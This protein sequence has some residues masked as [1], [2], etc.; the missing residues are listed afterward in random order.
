MKEINDTL[1]HNMGDQALIDAANVLRQTYRMADIIARVGGDEF[2]VLAV[3][4]A[5]PDTG[6]L[7]ERLVDHLREFN[8]S[9]DRP[10]V[11]SVS[12]GKS[13]WSSERTAVLD[14]MLSEAD[15]RMYAEKRTKKRP[16]RLSSPK[17]D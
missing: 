4:S 11:L 13:I 12:I 15:T 8:A 1:G 2:A 7:N 9:H 5:L 3:V 14:S 10:Y 16:P 17:A 6:S